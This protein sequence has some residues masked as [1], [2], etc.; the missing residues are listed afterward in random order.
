MEK[1]LS[2]KRISVFGLCLVGFLLS[3]GLD[4]QKGDL[5]FV[6]KG[7]SDF[8]EAISSATH[9]IGY[10][11][12]FVHVAIYYLSSDSIPSVIEASPE[13]GVRTISLQDF[14]K[15]I[16]REGK[17]EHGVV[18]K[19]LSTEFHID[20]A[21]DRAMTFIGQPYDWH[22][23]PDN[24][25]MYCSELIY[26]SFVSD[27]GYHFFTSQPMNFRNPDGS[28]PE[29]WTELYKTLGVD[30]P[31]GIPGTNPNDLSR[32]PRLIEVARF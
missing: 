5:L 12:D 13:Y 20:Y 25:M 3:F 27:D 28:M 32:D 24:G 17:N 2:V 15:D 30:V 9:D 6:S 23:L 8:S 7:N 22:Y 29:F 14:K 21:I 19:R 11:D 16:N 26:E 18:V 1:I 10:P 4:L 31:E